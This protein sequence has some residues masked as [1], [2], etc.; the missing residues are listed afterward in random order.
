MNSLETTIAPT[1]SATEVMTDY[2]A[3]AKRGDWDTAYGYFAEDMTVHIPGESAFAGDHCGRDA[4]IEYINAVRNHFMND[5]IELE[6]V[7]MLA[8]EERVALLVA[9]RFFGDDLPI[10]IR[11]AN[12]YRVRGGAIVE[13]S[14]FEADQYVVDAMIGEIRAAA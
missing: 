9:E 13:I 2:L 4:A 5:G 1:R 10:T 7:D 12:V 3:A 11:R 8:G 14:I 6:V